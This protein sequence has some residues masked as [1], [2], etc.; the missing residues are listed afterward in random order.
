[1]PK[2]CPRPQ[3]DSQAR[4]T[5]DKREK[6]VLLPG[7]DHSLEE[8]TAVKNADSVKEH[9]Q[10]RQAD[11][12]DD[13]GFGCECA[14]GEA[15]EKNGADAKREAEDVDLANQV[16]HADRQEGRQDG[17]ASDDVASKVQHVRSPPMSADQR[18]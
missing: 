5:A 11:R 16:T 13:L 6:V 10:A 7:A 2:M 18:A 1:M 9:D 15:D 12:P 17:L 4:Q 8:L 14:D 3:C